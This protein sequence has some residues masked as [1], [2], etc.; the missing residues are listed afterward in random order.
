MIHLYQ[1]NFQAVATENKVTNV[2]HAATRKPLHT[3]Q[4][5]VKKLLLQ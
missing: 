1:S 3:S 5:V 2:D 4:H